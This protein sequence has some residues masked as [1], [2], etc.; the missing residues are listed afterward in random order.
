MVLST[1]IFCIVSTELVNCVHNNSFAVFDFT[2]MVVIQKTIVKYI[3]Y[4]IDIDYHFLF[5][6]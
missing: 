4:N 2:S 5:D 1:K 3:I 6:I